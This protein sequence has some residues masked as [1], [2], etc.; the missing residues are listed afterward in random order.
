M[1]AYLPTDGVSFD[2]VKAQL[3]LLG[4]D[5]PDHVVRTF[6]KDG[7]TQLAEQVADLGTRPE[8]QDETW[9]VNYQS[10]RLQ[11][12][13]SVNGSD[14]SLRRSTSNQDGAQGSLDQR[15]PDAQRKPSS[16]DSSYTIRAIPS[17]TPGRSDVDTLPVSKDLEEPLPGTPSGSPHWPGAPASDLSLSQEHEAGVTQDN[18]QTEGS[19]SAFDN[20]SFPRMSASFMDL[21]LKE[22]RAYKG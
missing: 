13:P 17:L 15:N 10:S 6:L 21:G 7:S 9:S 20:D 11:R 4:H 14:T 3:I 19:A 18:T 2:A 22:V 12:K 5:I 1:Q 8:E 16:A